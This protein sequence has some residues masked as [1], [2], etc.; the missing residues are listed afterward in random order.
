MRNHQSRATRYFHQMPLV[1]QQA[2]TAIMF[3]V[4]LPL[5]AK[6]QA[7]KHLLFLFRHILKLPLIRQP[8]CCCYQCNVFGL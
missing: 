1:L 5:G 2:S 7:I 8:S 3:V 4:E 6:N